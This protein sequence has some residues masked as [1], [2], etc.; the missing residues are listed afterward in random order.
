MGMT[1]DFALAI[2]YGSTNVR[3]GSAI[4]GERSYPNRSEDVKETR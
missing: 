2:K 1:S 4:F 3:V